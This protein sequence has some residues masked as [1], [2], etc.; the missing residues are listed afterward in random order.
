M[1]RRI[2]LHQR[3]KPEYLR[4][5]KAAARRWMQQMLVV[6]P[7]YEL[8]LTLEEAV[9]KSVSNP[10]IRRHELMVRMRGFED[11]AAEMSY[12]G[13]FITWTSPGKYHAW[14]QTPNGRVIENEKYNGSTPQ[15]TQRY[16]EPL[17]VT[18]SCCISA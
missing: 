16:F 1:Q 2:S 15:Q 4:N 3:Q 12:T 5:R 9:S 14:K 8:E 18:V 13:V 7:Q 11:T 10:E 17:M 6:N